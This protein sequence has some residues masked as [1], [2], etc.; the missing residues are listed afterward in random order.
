VP[1]CQHSAEADLHELIGEGRGDVPLVLLHYR[2]SNCHGD[3]TDFVV[4]AKPDF[5]R[6]P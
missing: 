1:C 4:M 3:M 6:P 5:L 2:C